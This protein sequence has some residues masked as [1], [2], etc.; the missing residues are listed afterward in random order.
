MNNELLEYYNDELKTIR[1]LAKEFIK[2]H[3]HLSSHLNANNNTQ[4]DPFVANDE[5][6]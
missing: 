5:Y 1:Q 3:P 6:S 2:S 4:Q